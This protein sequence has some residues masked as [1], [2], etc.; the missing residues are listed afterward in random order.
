MATLFDKP[1]L[2]ELLAPADNL[3]TVII[4]GVP[5]EVEIADTGCSLTALR[6][7]IFPYR[8]GLWDYL[9][10]RQG[11][12][13]RNVDAGVGLA[14][15][16]QSKVM[17]VEMME[18]LRTA[19]QGVS[20]NSSGNA[21]VETV[22]QLLLEWQD[23]PATYRMVTCYIGHTITTE[24]ENL[25][26]YSIEDY[27]PSPGGAG[28]VAGAQT[29]KGLGCG[30]AKTYADCQAMPK[31]ALAYREGAVQRV[32]VSLIVKLYPTSA[33]TSVASVT[34]DYDCCTGLAYNT[35]Y[36]TQRTYTPVV[37]TQVALQGIEEIVCIQP[38]CGWFGPSIRCSEQWA[39]A[40]AVRY[41][42]ISPPAVKQLIL[43]TQTTRCSAGAGGFID[44]PIPDNTSLARP[45]GT[46][47]EPNRQPESHCEVSDV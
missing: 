41:N 11:L 44:L 14:A 22:D 39:A 31:P 37:Q 17:T 26:T 38:W 35:L 16:T 15:V 13:G 47:G 12:Y 10:L 45:A 33:G 29:E 28:G 2:F 24:T 46:A 36:S 7:P 21:P 43:R 34:S 4:D 27:L 25:T 23:N 1:L 9:V 18:A 6:R 30:E 32:A 42:A 40:W 8:F 19:G 5:T 3:A 20:S